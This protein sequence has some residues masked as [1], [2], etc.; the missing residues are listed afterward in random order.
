[1]MIL[2]EKGSEQQILPDIQA[3]GLASFPELNP[4]P[5][6]ETD[7]QGRVSYLNPAARALFPDLAEQG[8]AHLLLAQIESVTASLL[9]SEAEYFEREVD[10]G[11]SVFEERISVVKL[12]G[13]PIVRVYAHDVTAR[14]RAEQAISEM[15]R[16]VVT[17]QEE[18]RHRVSRELHDEAGQALVALKLSL[19][20]LESEC[21]DPVAIRAGLT[22]AIALVDRTRE[23]VRLIAHA[24]R[25]PSLDA[26]GLNATLEEFCRD[27]GRRTNL[28][29]DYRGRVE[30]E[31]ADAVAISLYRFLQEALANAA[32]HARAKRV[33]VNLRGGNQMIALWVRDDGIGMDPGII[34]RSRRGQGIV[35]MKE[36]I[37]LL[38]GSMW[39]L[40]SP[41][42][43]AHLLARLPIGS[44]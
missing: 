28:M 13:Q 37:E 43:G 29:I 5:V 41:G 18:E 38:S 23:Q 22:D 34:G 2:G 35:G 32:V 7:R 26:L 39:V 4:N 16:R 12:P 8:A 42:K 1:M 3:A 17:A 30:V 31:P 9:A 33:D 15:A 6:I 19:Q 20:M 11:D 14:R 40:S 10:L 25:P 21:D 24:L 27:F 44:Q 36:R